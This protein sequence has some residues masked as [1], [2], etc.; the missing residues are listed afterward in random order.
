MI[1]RIL[2]FIQ[3]ANYNRLNRT[4]I[5]WIITLHIVI[6]LINKDIVN[7]AQILIF[8]L[9]FFIRSITHDT[10]Y[11]ATSCIIFELWQIYLQLLFDLINELFWGFIL[12]CFVFETEYSLLFYRRLFGVMLGDYIIRSLSDL[13][14]YLIN[15]IKLSWLDYFL[16][17]LSLHFF[18]SLVSLSIIW[19][20]ILVIR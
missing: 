3:I 4:A 15:L 9:I 2:F 6:R 19:T 13:F 10:R 11:A 5:V 12:Q 20:K 8:T 14:E 18:K 7:L 1:S 16:E 17:N